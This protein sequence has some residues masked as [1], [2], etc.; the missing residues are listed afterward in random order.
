MKIFIDMLMT[1][2]ELKKLIFEEL[3]R[4]TKSKDCPSLELDEA[5]NKI[6]KDK[7]NGRSNRT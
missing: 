3:E 5:I 7:E 2:A 6:K 4:M 1:I